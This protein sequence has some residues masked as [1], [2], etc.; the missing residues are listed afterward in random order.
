M[1]SGDWHLA[2]KLGGSDHVFRRL[3]NYPASDSL[4]LKHPI[5]SNYLRTCD[6]GNTGIKTSFRLVEN[7]IRVSTRNFFNAD[8]YEAK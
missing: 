1:F 5:P 3:A 7:L 2:P 6:R 4:S 8:E